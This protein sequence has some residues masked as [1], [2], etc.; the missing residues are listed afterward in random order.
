M[1]LVARRA[2]SGRQGG[3]R[4]ADQTPAGLLGVALVLE[5]EQPPLSRADDQVQVAVRVQVAEG[6]LGALD[7]FG[8]KQARPAVENPIV[9]LAPG[10]DDVLRTG[11]G[12][13]G[14]GGIRKQEERAQHARQRKRGA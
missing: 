9:L 1:R 12:I 11:D 2:L 7:G 13:G 5:I 6:G 3:H 8:E 10:V 4:L 14:P